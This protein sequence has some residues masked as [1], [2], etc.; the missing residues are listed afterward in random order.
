MKILHVCYSLTG[1]VL[2][3][4]LVEQDAGL[5]VA[6]AFAG[7]VHW[8]LAPRIRT[9]FGLANL[10]AAG[11]GA[12][13]DGFDVI[14]LHTTITNAGWPVGMKTRAP[15]V[16]DI[17]DIVPEALPAG[18]A[19]VAAVVTPGERMAAQ[20]RSGTAKPVH[21]VYSKVPRA[22]WP[23]W[24]EPIQG[25]VGLISAVARE[26][27]YRDYR[28]VH[29]MLGGRL[30]VLSAKTPCDLADT[31][32]VLEMV[33]YQQSLQKLSQFQWGWAGAANDRHRID[34]CVTNKLWE[35]LAC[36]LP[37]ITWRSDEMTELA[38]RLRVGFEWDGRIESP[39][40]TNPEYWRNYRF[41]IE[42]Q[43]EEL[44]M[45]A[46]LP[47]LLEVYERAAA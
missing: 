28:Q 22:L 4:V 32:N 9:T 46:E 17:H 40:L 37:V 36:G 1:R 34:E 45:E 8:D 24:R 13:C 27:V 33:Q 31:M 10:N 19:A 21:A 5:D 35:S 12:I 3:Q 11:L 2:K 30:F 42:R 44:S 43:R 7:T 39:K 26:P 14:H 41:Q 15:I 29:Q 25:T 6:A 16:W 20:V 23:T 18:L 47:K 38:L